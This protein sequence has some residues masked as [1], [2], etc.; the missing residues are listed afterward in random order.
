MIAMISRVLIQKN[1][2]DGMDE[3]MAISNKEMLKSASMG[4]KRWLLLSAQTNASTEGL[5]L[6]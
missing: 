5:S 4:W 6:S 2:P 3:T 1:L